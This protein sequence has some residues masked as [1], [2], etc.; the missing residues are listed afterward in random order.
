MLKIRLQRVGRKHE[1]TFRLVLTDSKNSTKSGRYKE[2]L[3]SYDPRKSGEVINADRVKHWLGLG[4]SPTGTVHNLLISHKIID[5]KKVNVLPKKSPP[6]VEAKV[7]E[8]PAEAPKEEAPKTE[9]VPVV[10][11]PAP[12]AEEPTP[13][14]APE[15]VKSD[16]IEETPVEVPAESN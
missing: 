2:I 15:E 9:E 1:P 6:P 12:V 13:T 16:T 5:G 3:G 4:A 11:E 10:E 14:P 8:K 7:E